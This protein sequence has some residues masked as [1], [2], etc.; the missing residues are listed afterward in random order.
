MIPI[1]C[2]TSSGIQVFADWLSSSPESLRPLEVLSDQSLFA[3]I[4][5]RQIDPDKVFAS[6]FEFGTYLASQLAGEEHANLMLPEYDGM[7][8]WINACYFSQLAEKKIRKIEHYVPIRRGARGSLLHRNASRNAYDLYAT[9]GQN[10]FFCLRQPMHT[11]GQLLESISASQ[12]IVRN[13]GFFS[14]ASLLYLKPDGT[15]KRGFA[16]KPKKARDRKPGDTS[17]KGSVR[18]LPTA[19]KRLD[20]TYDVQ[21]VEPSQL[22]SMLPPEF[23]RW[24]TN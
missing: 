24:S 6:R 22:I 10:A 1:R 21:I 20:L 4:P 16:S 9:H 14:A 17:G 18:R 12:S 2:L 19:L 23:A 11:H 7:W 8:A 13:K 3:E 5:G 15:L